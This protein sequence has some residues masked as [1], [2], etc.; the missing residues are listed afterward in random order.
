MFNGLVMC[1]KQDSKPCYHDLPLNQKIGGGNK[2]VLKKSLSR[3][4]ASSDLFSRRFAYLNKNIIFCD[5]DQPD[6]KDPDPSS[7]VWQGQRL[8]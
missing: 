2:L 1:D 4:E 5:E 7:L 6:P 3:G 8:W